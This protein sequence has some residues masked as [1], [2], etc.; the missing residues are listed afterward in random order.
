MEMKRIYVGDMET[1]GITVSSCWPSPCPDPG[2]VPCPWTGWRSAGCLP[3]GRPDCPPRSW[4]TAGSAGRGWRWRSFLHSKQAQHTLIL[5]FICACVWDVAM[6]STSGWNGTISSMLLLIMKD[7][8][9]SLL[10]FPSSGHTK[11]ALPSS[12]WQTHKEAHL[13][14]ADPPKNRCPSCMSP[15][16]GTRVAT[17]TFLKSTTVLPFT[18][19]FWN[20]SGLEEMANSSFVLSR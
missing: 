9:F 1:K 20:T 15:L 6:R 17:F 11:S 14:H 13:L 12:N 8:M 5:I 10:G 4:R 16:G 7:V 18:S 2:P 3:P 19:Y